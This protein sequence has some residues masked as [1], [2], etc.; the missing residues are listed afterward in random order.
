MARILAKSV[1]HEKNTILKNITKNKGTILEA[2]TRYDFEKEF[3]EYS[4]IELFRTGGLY[5]T[6]PS[7]TAAILAAVSFTF[8][9]NEKELS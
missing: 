9:E 4:G 7:K 5:Y 6:H 8:H 2:R 1:I 3:E